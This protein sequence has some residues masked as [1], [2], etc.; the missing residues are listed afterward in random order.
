[1]LYKKTAKNHIFNYFGQLSISKIMQSSVDEY[2][3]EYIVEND[4]MSKTMLNHINITLKKILIFAQGRGW[5]ENPIIPKIEKP[6]DIERSVRRCFVDSEV[7]DLKS[8]A[9]KWFDERPDILGRALVRFM[10]HFMPAT[11]CRINDIKMLRWK[12]YKWENED[13]L[14]LDMVDSVEEF[15]GKKKH[16]TAEKFFDLLA[17]GS[18]TDGKRVYLKVFLQGKKR[19]RWVACDQEI[20]KHYITWNN[21]SN[22]PMPDDY[23]F[24]ASRPGQKSLFYV[25]HATQF[26]DLLECCEI[27]KA[28]NGEERAPYSLRHTFI[29]NKLKEG[30]NIVG[31]AIMCGASVREIENTYIHLLPSDIL[32]KI[33]KAPSAKQ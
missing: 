4:L 21:L 5:Y 10:I 9:D 13:G 6:K 7:D 24:S 1:M 25:P 30:A 11:G 14:C 33:F 22:N 20:F 15:K 29:T 32:K 8:G 23:V 18:A 16:V 26:N 3:K 2:F 19:P 28:K 17:I 27:S 12:D 31:I